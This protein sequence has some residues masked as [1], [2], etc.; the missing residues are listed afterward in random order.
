MMGGE[1]PLSAGLERWGV[2]TLVLVATWAF[3]MR[4]TLKSAHCIGAF[5][6][7]DTLDSYSKTLIILLFLQ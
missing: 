6:L 1:E 4:N 7:H 3:D 5:G 2:G